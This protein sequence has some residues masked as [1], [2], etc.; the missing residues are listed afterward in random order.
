MNNKPCINFVEIWGRQKSAP[1]PNGKRVWW[2]AEYYTW[3]DCDDDASIRDERHVN[4]LVDSLIHK[5]SLWRNEKP[6]AT[7]TFKP[8]FTVAIGVSDTRSRVS[9]Y[10]V[11]YHAHAGC[12]LEIIDFGMNIYRL[13]KR[14]IKRALK[15]G[16]AK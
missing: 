14:N 13:I 9:H 5:S 4:E 3:S 16:Q 7:D 6:E 8:W 10:T 15:R 1:V 12:P 11:D 2:D